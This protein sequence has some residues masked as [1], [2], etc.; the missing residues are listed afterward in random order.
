MA[1]RFQK[2]IVHIGTEKTGTSSIQ[3]SFA[4]N[5]KL[6]EAQGYYYPRCLGQKNHTRLAAYARADNTMDNL[7][8]RALRKFNVDLPGFRVL[9]RDLLDEETQDVD[10]HT[11]LVSNEHLHSRLA[12]LEEKRRVHSFLSEFAESFEVLAYLRRQDKVAV[13]VFGTQLRAG[14]TDFDTVLPNLSSGIPHYYDYKRLLSEYAQVFGCDNL[15]VREFDRAKL[16]D[17]D[18]VADVYDAIGFD[19]FAEVNAVAVQNESISSEAQKFLS[20]LNAA[21]PP[22]IGQRPNP[23]RDG[24]AGVMLNFAGQGRAISRDSAKAFMQHF[25][26]INSWVGETFF[27]DKSALFDQDYSSFPESSEVDLSPEKLVEMGVFLYTWAKQEAAEKKAEL[28]FR[29]GL[30][31]LKDEELAG[32]ERLFERVIDFDGDHAGAHFQLAKLNLANGKR[33]LAKRFVTRAIELAPAKVDYRIWFGD[34][35]LK[36]GQLAQAET[37]YR[38][39]L[40]IRTQL[41]RAWVG[42][43]CSVHQQG[44]QDELQQLGAEALA[45]T[46]NASVVQQCVGAYC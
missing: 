15:R 6:L 9:L 44:R 3:A 32:A 1:K 31:C 36:R 16:K 45:A 29:D 2:C 25:E 5:R 14:G 19:A 28:F 40:N 37:H 18:V 20:V 12:S 26:D 7:R 4:A 11:L 13:S 43:I 10:C 23:L 30:Q 41:P 46:E 17:G 33:K 27:G 34:V 38:A 39:A 8:K 35:L 21:V 24:L 22:F 42:L